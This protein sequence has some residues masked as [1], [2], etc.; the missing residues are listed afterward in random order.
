MEW[1][2]LLCPFYGRDNSSPQIGKTDGFV[3]ESGESGGNSGKEICVHYANGDYVCLKW[4]LPVDR[5]VTDNSL[6]H[7]S[8]FVMKCETF[9]QML[10]N[11]GADSFSGTVF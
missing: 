6:K 9:F 2:Y 1:K 11:P 10:F 3:C 8:C 7:V 5:F 4:T